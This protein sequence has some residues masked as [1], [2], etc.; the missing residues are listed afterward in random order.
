MLRKSDIAEAISIEENTT[1]AI[2]ECVYIRT[3]TYAATG[4]ITRLSNIGSMHFIHL[5]DAAWIPDSDRWMQAIENGVLKEIEPVTSQVRV[6]VA[7]IVD[8][9]CWNHPLPRKQK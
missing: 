2:G 4:R 7:A 1:F 9:W 6:A 8:V 5:E 3:V